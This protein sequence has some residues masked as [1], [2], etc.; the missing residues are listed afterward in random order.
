MMVGRLL[1]FCYG[2]FS[3]VNSPLNFQ[4]VSW[5][6]LNPTLNALSAPWKFR[7]LWGEQPLSYPRNA[8]WDVHGTEQ[9]DYN[10]NPFIGKL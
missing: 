2:I 8:T 6:K 9:M 1:S 5:A 10:Y 4:G 3:G 7:L